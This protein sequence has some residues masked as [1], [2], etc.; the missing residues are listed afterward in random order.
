MLVLTRKQSE[1]IV[2]GDG[3]A[4][5]V[6]KIKKGHVKLGIEADKKVRIDRGEVANRRAA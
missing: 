6:L 1:R 2:I 5:T 3:I 4:V